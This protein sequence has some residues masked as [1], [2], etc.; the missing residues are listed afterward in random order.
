MEDIWVLENWFFEKGDT[1][2]YRFPHSGSIE[3]C[4][5]L[6][7]HFLKY[8]KA[9]DIQIYEIGTGWIEGKTMDKNHLL[10]KYKVGK[11]VGYMRISPLDDAKSVLEYNSCYDKE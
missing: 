9:R 8:D 4:Y 2:G 6:A 10:L 1:S 5:K 11:S 3:N 7:E